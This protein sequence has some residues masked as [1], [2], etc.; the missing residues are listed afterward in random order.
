MVFKKTNYYNVYKFMNFMFILKY[1]IFVKWIKSR[2]IL[3][4][5]HK[6][7]N[8]GN[9]KN[10]YILLILRLIKK[11]Y[12]QYDLIYKII[13]INNNKI[14]KKFNYDISKSLLNK[15]L[16]FIRNKVY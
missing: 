11:K 1:N 6:I 10:I 3:R 5:I 8:F 12:F 4:K 15:N 2:I 16:F 14:F 9:F 13:I 7:Y